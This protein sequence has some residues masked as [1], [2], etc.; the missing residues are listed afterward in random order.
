MQK[1]IITG[2]IITI[3]SKEWFQNKKIYYTPTQVIVKDISTIGFRGIIVKTNK[4]LNEIDGFYT[5]FGGSVYTFS[6]DDVVISRIKL[7]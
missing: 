5:L 2:T 6:T 3:N 1:T 4:P 7:K